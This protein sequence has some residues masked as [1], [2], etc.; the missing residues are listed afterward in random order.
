[1]HRLYAVIVKTFEFLIPRVV[2]NLSV[3][4]RVVFRA[5][6]LRRSIL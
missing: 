2:K 4:Q 6:D 3:Y 5:G 1:M